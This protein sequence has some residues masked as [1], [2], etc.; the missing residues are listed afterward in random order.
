MPMNLVTFY[1]KLSPSGL[2]ANG[3]T[4]QLGG[5]RVRFLQPALLKTCRIADLEVQ[6]TE[7]GLE[8]VKLVCVTDVEF[9]LPKWPRRLLTVT[10]EVADGQPVMAIKEAFP[11][12][13]PV[14][15]R[16]QLLPQDLYLYSC[17]APDNEQGRAFASQILR[18]SR[19]LTDTMAGFEKSSGVRLVDDA[20]GFATL[21][22]KPSPERYRRLVLLYTLAI[23]YQEQLQGYLD[24]FRE[25][26]FD[27]DDPALF[28][29]R[30]ESIRFNAQYYF[31]NPVLNGRIELRPKWRP[32]A[33]SFLL[34]ETSKEFQKQL[35]SVAQIA[36][37]RAE[38]RNEQR[39]T[40]AHEQQE[41]RD[42]QLQKQQHYT[43]VALAVIGVLLAALSLL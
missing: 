9:F 2:P 28:P 31:D 21:V 34:R 27:D 13:I 4:Y 10:V 43:N 38:E 18:D 26:L 19:T 17:T 16:T 12:Q 7:L 6:S 25:A 22:D 24:R 36:A 1:Y 15:I 42:A 39:H 35:D 3:T 37:M 8:G 33:D 41:Q 32:L 11:Q 29:L 23:A 30:E 40:E 14:P 5:R 20:K